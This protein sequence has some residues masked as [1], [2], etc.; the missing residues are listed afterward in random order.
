[1]EITEFIYAVCVIFE[2]V[3]QLHRLFAEKIWEYVSFQP[4]F[5]VLDEYRSALNYI[6]RG[7]RPDEIV[8]HPRFSSNIALFIRVLAHTFDTNPRFHTSE[9]FIVIWLLFYSVLWFWCYVF[10]SYFTPVQNLRASIIYQNYLSY[11]NIQSRERC[12]FFE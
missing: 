10:I 11:K 7:R 9:I 1:M 8:S 2:V 6:S 4:L 5:W 3:M 12:Y